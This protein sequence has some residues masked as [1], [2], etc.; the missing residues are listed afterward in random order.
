MTPK[1]LEKINLC[2]SRNIDK[3]MT[4]HVTGQWYYLEDTLH[5]GFFSSPDGYFLSIKEKPFVVYRLI[6]ENV[7]ER[8][9]ARTIFK[10]KEEAIR[11]LLSGIKQEEEW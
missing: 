6:K 7:W 9:P 5:I 4:N 10:S 2:I 3:F 1:D 11:C 8:S